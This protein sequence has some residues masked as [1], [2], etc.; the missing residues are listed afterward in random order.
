MNSEKAYN[1]LSFDELKEFLEEK[2]LKF[3]TLS[4]IDADPI[5]IPHRFSSRADREIAGFLAATIAWGRR[6]LI[7]K[8]SNRLMGLL[9]NA[10]HDFIINADDDDIEQLTGFVYRTFNGHDCMV[11]IHG[12][13][14]IFTH[15]TSVEDVI[16]E[17][18]KA[19]NGS[20]ISG[21][22]HL[23]NVFFSVNHTRRSEKHFA[24]VAA[25]S[26]GKRLFMYLRWMARKDT[27][28]VDFGIWNRINP[29]ELFIPLDLHS[30]NTARKTGLLARKQNDFKAVAEL[31]AELRKFDPYDPVKYDFALF[32]LGVNEKF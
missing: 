25:G 6:D 32:G 7:L 24:N 19:A 15:Y 22:S 23:R 1:G 5:S 26:A 8:S 21:L 18:M 30:G 31:T 29:S 16:V 17:G 3:N 9:Q 28:G 27:K 12:L 14:H 13:R 2:Y 10:P 4:F 20:L 11:F